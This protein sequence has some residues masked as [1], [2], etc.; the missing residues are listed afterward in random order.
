MKG[1]IITGGK[2]PQKVY[3]EKFIK[4]AVYVV[5]ADSGYDNALELGIKPHCLIGDMDSIIEKP[6]ENMQILTFPI[7]K[8]FTDTELAAIN[9]YEKGITEY[10]LIGGGEGRL[11]HLISLLDCYS[12]DFY[13]K[14]W[15][16]EQEIIY[17]VTSALQLELAQESCISLFNPCSRSA[18]V[19]TKGLF[20]ELTKKEI[21]RGTSSI[22]NKNNT[23]QVSVEVE[24]GGLI[25]VSVQLKIQT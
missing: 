12:G 10:I 15:I 17:A 24:G 3:I 25:L 16:T 7:N 19:S 6:A 22:S 21:K 18:V 13:P 2:I 14:I 23:K 4:D 11:D 20:W 1:L 8:D 9:L 5:A